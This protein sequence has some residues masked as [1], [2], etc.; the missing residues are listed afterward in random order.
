MTKIEVNFTIIQKKSEEIYSDRD[1]F[2][3]SML[4]FFSERFKNLVQK[5][6]KKKNTISKVN[7]KKKQNTKTHRP[8]V[9]K[10]TEK[11]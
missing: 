8:I 11:M 1:Y 4:Y 6:K 7:A 2:T 5:K 10:A 9:M 3:I